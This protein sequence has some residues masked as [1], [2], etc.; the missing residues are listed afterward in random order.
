MNGMDAIE[1]GCGTGYVSG[2]CAPGARWWESTSRPNSS[3]PPAV[4]PSS[5]V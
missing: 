5:T 3:G 2:G 4:S 1:L